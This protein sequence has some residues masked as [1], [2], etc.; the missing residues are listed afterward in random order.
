MKSCT[1]SDNSYCGFGVSVCENTDRDHG[2]WTTTKNSTLLENDME[3]KK[4]ASSP[5]VISVLE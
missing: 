4:K 5:K 2:V 3:V 1:G